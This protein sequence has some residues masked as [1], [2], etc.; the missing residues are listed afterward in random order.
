MIYF[1]KDRIKQAREIKKLT[2]KQLAEKVGVSE[3]TISRWES[4]ERIPKATYLSNLSNV[5][6]VPV[7]YFY[8]WI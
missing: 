3:V 7:G 1:E 4:G 5:L 2:Q 8:L 6:D